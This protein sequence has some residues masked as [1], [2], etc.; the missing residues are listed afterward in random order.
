MTGSSLRT[1]SSK[2]FLVGV[3][4]ISTSLFADQIKINVSPQAG[5]IVTCRTQIE[6]EG[7]VI[8]LPATSEETAPTIELRVQALHNFDQIHVDRQ[9]ALRKYGDAH[10]QISLDKRES[11]SALTSANQQIIVRRSKPGFG[12]PIQYF[13]L[14]SNLTQTELELLLIP[15]DLLA[16]AEVLQKDSAKISDQWAPTDQAAQALFSLDHVSENK[17]NLSLKEVSAQKAAKLF[18]TGEVRGEVDGC[19]TNIR[20]S[21][22]ALVDLN[23][24]TLKAFRANIAE[25]RQPSQLAPGFNGTVKV[26]VTSVIKGNRDLDD[27]VAR[28]VSAKINE[29]QSSKLL[30]NSDSE[31]ELVYDPQWRLI[32]SDSDVVLMRYADQGNV[33]AQ[34]NIMSLPKRPENSPLSLEEFQAQLTKNVIGNSQAKIQ[35]AE[36]I[37]TANGLTAMQVNVAGIQDEI[38]ITWLYYHLS[39]PSGRCVALVFIAEDAVIPVLKNADLKL[40][41]SIRFVNKERKAETGQPARR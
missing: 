37:T 35:H 34:C 33:L 25:N 3:F 36:S 21:A 28:Q 14:G 30:W 7:E 38:P 1:I 13:A 17:L 24:S 20:I 23:S 6:F 4:T 11:K 22:V 9:N 41:E 26:D 18:I 8:G 10:A 16:V 27:Q 5:T 39:D 19:Q 31:F 32:L 15:C 2:F 12:R 29:Q 40:V